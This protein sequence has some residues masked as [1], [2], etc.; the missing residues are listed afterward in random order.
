MISSA[1]EGQKAKRKSRKSVLSLY[2]FIIEECHM[3]A[4]TIGVN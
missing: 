1:A 3:K 2:Q 4:V